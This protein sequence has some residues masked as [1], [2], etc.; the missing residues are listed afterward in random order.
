MYVHENRKALANQGFVVIRNSLSQKLLETLCE[1]RDTVLSQLPA[2]HRDEYKSQGSLVNLGDHPEFSHLIGSTVIQDLITDLGPAD[3]RW[4]AGYLISKPP[5]SPALFWHQDWWGWD[6]PISYTGQL[7]GLGVMIYL[8]D[9][10]VENGCL[11]VIPGSHRCRHRLHSL[12][13]A[14][15]QALSHIDD[16]DDIAYQSDDSE[17]AVEVQAGDVVLM[18]PRLLHGAYANKTDGERSLITLWFLP[19]FESLPEPIQARYVQIFNRHELDTGDTAAGNLLD[20]WPEKHRRAIKNL[21]PQYRG[22]AEPHPWNRAPD[23]NQML[24]SLDDLPAG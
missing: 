13:I 22:R 5:K 9:T 6:H 8:S 14:H 23:Q 20:S 12:P 11:R 4:L 18:D 21:E 2:E 24:T 16:P 7:L 1:Q 3:S 19:E 17:M 10:C 15:E